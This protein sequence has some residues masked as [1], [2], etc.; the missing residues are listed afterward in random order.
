MR[1]YEKEEMWEFRL[2]KP[3][4]IGSKI[5]SSF[6]VWTEWSRLMTHFEITSM[7][8]ASVQFIYFENNKIYCRFRINLEQLELQDIFSPWLLIEGWIFP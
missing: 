3:V 6:F 5:K 4:K 2:G 7:C 1:A 8:A